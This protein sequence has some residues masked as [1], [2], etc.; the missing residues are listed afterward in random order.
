[1][2]S[3]F[4][5]NILSLGKWKPQGWLTRYFHEKT[6]GVMKKLG[7]NLK[8]TMFLVMFLSCVSGTF[9]AIN[10]KKEWRE[11]KAIKECSLVK[12]CCGWVTANR[13]FKTEIET[14]EKVACPSIECSSPPDF[15]QR[16]SL[17]CSKHICEAI[18]LTK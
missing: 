4:D 9:A 1:M 14:F 18:R 12:G 6:I 10:Y 17:S 8:F 13:R 16:P 11:C 2:A 5:A 7:S 15:E 3:R